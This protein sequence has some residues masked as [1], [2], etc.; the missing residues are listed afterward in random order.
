MT[1][2]FVALGV[3]AAVREAVA[4]ALEPAR[5]REPEHAWTDPAGWHVTLAFLGEL[6]DDRVPDAELAVRRAVDGAWVEEPAATGWRWWL[7]QPARF[8]RRVLVVE[9]EDDPGGAISRLGERIQAELA[10]AGLPVDRRPVRPH[11]TL[12]RSRRRTAITD[13]S[14][15]AVTDALRGGPIGR[16]DAWS[17]S[18]V[19]LW[20]AG[21]RRGPARYDIDLEVPLGQLRG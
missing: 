14:V 20:S 17:S 1:R 16:A 4:A 5:A 12:A 7:G 13:G 21:D 6:A 8:G 15:R 2:R 9:V 18:T 11:V 3:P 19:G 10:D